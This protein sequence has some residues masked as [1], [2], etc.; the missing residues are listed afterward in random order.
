M[1]PG[2][3]NRLWR[4]EAWIALAV[5]LGATIWIFHPIWPH[6]SSAVIGAPSDNVGYL[7]TLWYGHDALLGERSLLETKLLFHPDGT[8]L[9]YH[10]YSWVNLLLALPLRPFLELPAIYNLL[11][12]QTFPVAG[13]GAFLLT[14]LWVRDSFAAL[15]AGFLYAFNP[16]HCAYSLVQINSA[17]IQFLPFF[18]LFFVRTLRRPSWASR[19]AAA[20]FFLLN[21]MASWY[22]LV[23]ALLL[24]ALWIAFAAVR[25]GLPGAVRMLRETSRVAGLGLLPL[26]PWIAFMAGSAVGHPRVGEA[27]GHDLFVADLFGFFV[28]HSLHRLGD[29]PIVASMNARYTGNVPGRTAYLGWV[30]IALAVHAL[31]RSPRRA[32]ARRLALPALAFAVLAMGSH[33]HVAGV[34]TSVPLPTALLESLPLIGSARVPNRALVVTYLFLAVLAAWGLADGRRRL[35]SASAGRLLVAIVCLLVWLD[36][37]TVLHGRTPFD[38]P[39][40]Y[41]RIPRDEPGAGLVDLPLTPTNAALYLA[42]QTRHGLPVVE[43]YVGRQLEPSL[44]ER[45]RSLPPRDQLEALRRGRVRWIVVHKDPPQLAERA[46]RVRAFWIALGVPVH[47]ED[48]RVTIFRIPDRADRTDQESLR[49]RETSA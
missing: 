28:P 49:S 4:N 9:A 16:V 24:L 39:T 20:F 44:L 33:L 41:A 45:I 23:H 22:F 27:V 47:F 3:A 46:P 14:R 30:P 40:A 29:W 12:L 17:S 34:V 21:A 18:L 38:P 8:S 48:D 36:G 1:H 19:L 5:Y 7:W 13:L 6:L 35:R 37:P 43:G 10:V 11:I 42:Y 26:A 15:V 25:E 31:A 2:E 32:A